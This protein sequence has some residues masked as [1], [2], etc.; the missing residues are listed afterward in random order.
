MGAYVLAMQHHADGNVVVCRQDRIFTNGWRER[1]INFPTAGT[2]TGLSRNRGISATA[3][4]VTVLSDADIIAPEIA[5]TVGSDTFNWSTM[6]ADFNLL[7][8]DVYPMLYLNPASSHRWLYNNS[9]RMMVI[10]FQDNNYGIAHASGIW[11]ETGNGTNLF[12]NSLDR[13]QP[14]LKQSISSDVMLNV[15]YN[16]VNTS[17]QFVVGTTTHEYISHSTAGV[18][19]W[20]A[21]SINVPYV[22]GYNSTT[23][24]AYVKWTVDN[25]TI[26]GTLITKATIGVTGNIT[27]ATVSSTNPNEVLV[28]TTSNQAA[29][30]SN[31]GTSWTVSALPVSN[32]ET[33]IR[34]CHGN[35]LYVA[36]AT[37]DDVNVQHALVS[38]DGIN[39]TAHM[40]AFNGDSFLD[41]VGDNTRT[42]AYGNGI[43]VTVGY[44]ASG[45][46]IY[47]STD[48][49]VWTERFV[50]HFTS[51]DY[52]EFNIRK[53]VFGNG[54]F[55][56]TTQNGILFT[57]ANG[58]QWQ[59]LN[60]DPRYR[61]IGGFFVDISFIYE[62][63]FFVGSV[64][65]DLYFS[66][67]GVA[68]HKFYMSALTS[69]SAFGGL[70]SYN[71]EA[72][73][74]FGGKLVLILPGASASLCSIVESVSGIGWTRRQIPTTPHNLWFFP[75]DIVRQYAWHEY[76]PTTTTLPG[77]GSG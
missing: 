74:Q 69:S 28:V 73:H 70:L 12:Y 63:G 22:Y 30:T 29:I 16:Y 62:Y 3:S 58:I 6:P 26:A 37:T 59:P 72:I 15:K 41:A 7:P 24:T 45:G 18:T 17:K 34:V 8:T 47:T 77:S 10:S 21:T 75:D 20:N 23:S 68:W 11:M 60:R 56:I 46:R 61:Q 9:R 1:T 13:L 14:T 25:V 57:S 65:S 31:N 5:R 33:I 52:S 51:S 54:V 67:D 35:G 53:V 32:A 38:S 76:A 36:L 27:T 48:G 44:T 40:S 39:W 2:G 64:S 4:E 50:G 42:I 49:A 55:L 66:Y 19:D 71:V 43:F